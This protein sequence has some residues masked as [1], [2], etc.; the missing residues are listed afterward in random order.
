MAPFKDRREAG[1]LLAEELL[2]YKESEDV[3]VLGL[4]RGGVPVA[5]EV[6]KE[7][8]VPMDVF[9]V[10]K[11]G[12]PNQPELAMGAI[13]SGGVKIMNDSVVKGTGISDEQIEEV[14]EDEREK[15]QKREKA[16]RGTRPEVQLEDKTILLIDDGLATGASMRAAVTALREHQPRNI[17][18]AVPTAPADTCQSFKSEV[19]KVICLKTPTP[20]WGVG[21][22]YQDFSQ[23]TNEEVR[24]LLERSKSE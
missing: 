18:V 21:G 17:V 9:V 19:D 16:Y 4:P 15:L 7:L 10:R 8:G 23:T 11:L 6:A 13:A 3:V 5:Y 1:K 20:F 2:E 12:V 24:D 22:S 14:I